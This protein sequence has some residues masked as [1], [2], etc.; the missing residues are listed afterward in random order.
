MK[1]LDKYVLKEMIAPFLVAV[2]AFVVLLVGNVIFDSL[3]FILERHVPI[4]LVLR[5]VVFQ[6]P[7]IIGMV[8]PLAILFG[9]A[10]AVN[11]LGRDG[12]V[13]AIRMT[14]VPLRRIFMP[15][16][17]VGLIAS[18]LTLWLSE[19]VTP[20]AN[21]EAQKTIQY[22]WGMQNIPPIK[23]NV[24]FE[25]EGYYFYVQRVERGQSGKFTL[26]KVMIYEVPPAGQYPMMVT[27]AWADSKNNVWTLHDGVVHKIGNDGLVRYEMKFPTMQLNLNRAMQ[28]IMSAQQTPE[29]MGFRELSKQISMFQGAGQ[30]V[31]KLKVDWNFK[32]SMPLACLVFALCAAPLSLRFVSLGSYSGILLG[33]IIMFLYWNNIFLGKA[34]GLHGFLPPFLAGWSQ[35]FI[36]SAVGIYLIWREE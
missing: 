9:T 8:L 11:R 22:I 13:T 27:A 16:F 33:I 17:V 18:G 21:R 25:S 36:F 30:A 2:L 32:L 20:W 31:T 19:S 1:T 7:R 26:R 34:L 24:F 12:E 15:I 28:A 14:G 6:L 29:E 5:L 3:E 35:N 10:L 23:E 4:S